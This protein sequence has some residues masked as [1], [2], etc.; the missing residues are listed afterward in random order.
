MRSW[1]TEILIMHKMHSADKKYV[2]IVIQQYVV[3]YIMLLV[4]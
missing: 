4:A 1:K 3:Q 2:L